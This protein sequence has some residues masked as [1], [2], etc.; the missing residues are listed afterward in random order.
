VPAVQLRIAGERR[1][2]QLHT[3]SSGVTVLFSRL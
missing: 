3:K 1:A 2:G